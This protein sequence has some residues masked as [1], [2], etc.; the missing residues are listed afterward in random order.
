MRKILLLIMLCVILTGCSW[1]A[2]KRVVVKPEPVD[3]RDRWKALAPFVKNY[4]ETDMSVAEIARWLE[5]EYARQEYL[6]EKISE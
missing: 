3:I 6:I 1:C 2:D 5:A 4:F